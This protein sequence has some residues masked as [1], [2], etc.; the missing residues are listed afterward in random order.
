MS[1]TTSWPWLPTELVEQVMSVAWYSDLTTDERIT[2]MTSALL[3]NKRWKA[4]FT[5]IS[6]K[7]IHIPCPSYVF[8]FFQLLRRES[9]IYDDT[10]QILLNSLCRS[11][12]IKVDKDI[13]AGAED[14]PM[15]QALSDTLYNIDS[16]RYLPNLRTLSV[17]YP[18]DH[19]DDIFSGYRF[20]RFPGQITTL[21]LRYTTPISTS[22]LDRLTAIPFSLP[23]IRYLS[24]IGGTEA[25]VA[26][27]TYACSN[28]EVLE[29]DAHIEMGD[30]RALLKGYITSPEG[31]QKSP[32][33][34]TVKSAPES[35]A[36]GI[37][38][39]T[40]VYSG[41]DVHLFQRM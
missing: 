36:P 18:A 38:Q 37:W 14:P 35:N 4:S 34:L 5:H 27:F 9:P 6:A 19:C 30:Q 11:I 15:G 25:I 39:G 29:V 16:L 24:I 23:P 40:E 26:D 17:E 41:G 33:N 10:T 21:Q 31:Q 2:L 1:T 3:V 22:P 28:L 8:Q 13:P 20:A 12:T 7:D 32:L